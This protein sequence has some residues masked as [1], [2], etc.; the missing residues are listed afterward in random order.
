M[1]VQLSDHFTLKKLLRFVL[2]SVV[3]MIFTSIY[4]VVDGFFVSNFVGKTP[5]AAVNLIMPVLQMLGAIG[6]MLGT[7][8]SA[9]V[10]KKLGEGKDRKAK[11]IFSLMT[12]VGLFLGVFF[13]IIGFLF[14]KQ[15][16]IFLGANGELVNYCAVYG[17]I[18][19]IA[20]PFFVLQN[21]FQSFFVTAGKPNL[22]LAVTV[23]AG[24]TNMVFDAVLIIVFKT[25][26]AGAAIATAFSQ[27][28]ACVIPLTYFFSKNKSLLR[29]VKTHWDTRSLVHATI[30]GSS[31]FV[32]NISLSIVAI[33]Y[34]FQLMKYAGE[35]GVAA[36]GVIMYV[37][38]IF[39]TVFLGYSIGVAPIFGFNQGAN[40]TSELKN[41]FKKSISFVAIA[42]VILTAT[43]YILSSIM[44]KIFVGYDTELMEFTAHAFKIYSFSYVFTGFGI[45][46]SAL[47]TA[48]NNG[49]ISATISFLRTLVLQALAILVMPA[50]FGIEGIWFSIIVAESLATIVSLSFV[51]KYQKV[52]Q[53]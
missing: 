25:G 43:G 10:A 35:N 3:M 27:F 38:Y 53:Y 30:N 41:V 46:G 24:V 34:N 31:E 42:G 6:L 39:I 13:G 4:S 49:V 8:G 15:I 20:L 1:A 29:L 26:I 28:V 51:I 7:G 9:L 18:I 40:N 14:I 33:L 2:P 37:S 11:E 47:F 50:L 44:S 17:R 22:G 52:Y 45:F 16:A 12:Y 32:A 23:F 5:F 48:L 36:Y 21:M 19:L